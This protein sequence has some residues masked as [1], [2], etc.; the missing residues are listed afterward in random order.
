MKDHVLIVNHGIKWREQIRKHIELA[1]GFHIAAYCTNGLDAM[2]VIRN[3][4]IDLLFLEVEMP[5][6]T[7]IEFLR[8]FKPHPAV[9]LTSA[10][11]QFALEAFSLDVLDYLLQPI[12]FRRFMMALDKYDRSRPGSP[13]MP[14]SERGQ[15]NHDFIYIHEKHRILKVF[16]GEI[17]FIE[18]VRPDLIIQTEQQR[19]Q[20]TDTLDEMEARLSDGPFI[21]IHSKYLVSANKIR[22]FSPYCVE[23]DQATLPIEGKFR[24]Q[25]LRSLQYTPNPSRDSNSSYP[26]LINAPFCAS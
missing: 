15:D 11:D 6:L 8:S 5:G 12:S 22:A 23:L 4:R 2:E 19:I 17:C 3:S 21:R 1:G 25:A 10:C 14:F 13:G 26:S 16:A 9:I 20:S 24:S 18:E 7:G